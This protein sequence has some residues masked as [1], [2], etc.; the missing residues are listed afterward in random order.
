MRPPPA[1]FH[2]A[3]PV[4]VPAELESSEFVWV[5]K[6]GK[7]G[8]L[9]PSYDGPYRVVARSPKYFEIDLGNRVDKITVDRLKANTPW[10]PK[11]EEFLGSQ[12]DSFRQ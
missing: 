12:L 7:R 3:P 8:P 2:G 5:R 10:P 1:E 11:A 9:D 4:H 6:D